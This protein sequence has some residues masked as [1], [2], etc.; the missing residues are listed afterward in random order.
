MPR[1]SDYPGPADR[2]VI[3]LGDVTVRGDALAE[4]LTLSREHVARSR[5]EDGCISHD[6]H[7]H[8]DDENRL[9]FVERWRDRAA[10]EAHFAVPA[11]RDFA[12]ALTD[13]AVESPRMEIHQT[14]GD[15]T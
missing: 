2:L 1:G 12:R 9:V 8:A 11:S 6:V 3:V 7:L 10:L 13:L 15:R 5:T 14:T 4:A